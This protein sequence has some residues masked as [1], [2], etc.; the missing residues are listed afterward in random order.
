MPFVEMEYFDH[1]L[2][3]CKKP[4]K[5]AIAVRIVQG[6]AQG[7]S[8]AHQ[9]GVIHQDLKPHNI[10]LAPDLTPKITDWGLSR[11]FSQDTAASMAGFSLPYASPEQLSPCQFSSTG[12]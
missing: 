9:K 2:D 12:P 1:S 4:L 3:R 7:L 5:L 11:I 8:Y 6:I 10:L